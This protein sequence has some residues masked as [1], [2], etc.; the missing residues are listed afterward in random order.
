MKLMQ[1]K[2]FKKFVGS[3]NFSGVSIPN[4]KKIAN[5]FGIKY[6]KINNYLIYT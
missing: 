2:N 6:F 1:K 3:S 5:G 4:I